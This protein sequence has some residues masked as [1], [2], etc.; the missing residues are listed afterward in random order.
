MGFFLSRELGENPIGFFNT[1]KPLPNHG[2]PSWKNR[3]RVGIRK[4]NDFYLVFFKKNNLNLNKSSLK[5]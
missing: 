5:S 2:N 1:F 4:R 3:S